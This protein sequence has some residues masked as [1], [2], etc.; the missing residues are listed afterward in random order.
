M[1]GPTEKAIITFTL[2]LTIMNRKILTLVLVFITTLSGLGKPRER[3]FLQKAPNLVNILLEGDLRLKRL[4]LAISA[5]DLPLTIQ[6]LDNTSERFQTLRATLQ[7]SGNAWNTPEWNESFSNI[8]KA[9]DFARFQVEVRLG[10]VGDLESR[11]DEFLRIPE[12]KAGQKI[13]L[14]ISAARASYQRGQ[15][16]QAQQFVQRAEKLASDQALSPVALFNLRTAR[17]STQGFE[18]ADVDELRAGF[19]RAWEPLKGYQN[20]ANPLHD[21][22]W[23]LA[24]DAS[25]YWIDQFSRIGS[26]GTPELLQIYQKAI[27]MKNRSLAPWDDAILK[28]LGLS[29]VLS[30]YLKAMADLSV[31]AAFVDQI[32]SVSEALPAESLQENDNQKTLKEITF[33]LDSLPGIAKLHCNAKLDPTLATFELGQ[34][35]LIQEI[36]GRSSF[37]EARFAGSS[38]KPGLLD[39]GLAFISKSDNKPVQGSYLLKAARQFSELDLSNRAEEAWLQALKIANESDL[40]IQALEAE[41]RLAQYYLEEKNWE[42]AKE[43]AQGGIEGL[44][45]ALPFVGSDS[46]A[47]KELAKRSHALSSILAQASLATDDTG[48]ALAALNMGGDVGTAAAQMNGKSTP[49][50]E[51]VKIKKKK[52]AVLTEKVETLKEMPPSETRDALLQENEKLL[53]DTKSDFLSESRKIREENSALYSSVLRFDPLDLP[54]V[55]GVIPPDAA[56]VQYFPTDTTLYI[57]VVSKTSFVLRSLDVSRRNLDEKIVSLLSTITRPGTAPQQLLTVRREL[58]DALIA[59]IEKD[60]SEKDTLVLIP[61]GRLNFLPFA[62]LLNSEGKALL[63]EKLLLELAKPTDFLRIS[64]TDAGPV[65]SVVAFANATLDLPAAAKEGLAV[66]GLFDKSQLFQG[67]EA[68][69][70]NFFA[71]GGSKDVLHL[72]THGKWDM[73]DALESYLKLADGQKISQQDIFEMNLGNTSLVTLSACNTAVSQRHDV[74]FVASLAEAFWIAGS[75]SVVATLWSVDDDS[76]GLLMSEFYQGLKE[77][78]SKSESLRSAQL[79]VKRDLRFEHPYYWGGVVLFGDWR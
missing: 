51:Q 15:I 49:E 31:L 8:E 16:S 34:G 10:S 75:R 56:V 58:Y 3:P 17:F 32:V 62:T 35:G 30:G 72:A 36:K 5:A 68:S 44:K 55:Q 27:E 6:E 48:T 40:T 73:A 25:R 50:F 78:K 74:D 21:V 53:A 23:L 52:V 54:D 19:R 66:T 63:E 41:E 13:G 65:Q 9:L 42:K 24:R 20:K 33:L 60:I 1:P 57:F 26:D 71:H 2:N 11:V 39:A 59:P 18:T 38:E 14:L 28:E 77:G 79:A 67:T 70:E 22:D 47:A 37:L 12:L 61:A 29:P 69:K 7:S 46:R 43:H 64:S 45:Q 76:T 4:F